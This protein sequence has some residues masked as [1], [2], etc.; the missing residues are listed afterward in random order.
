MYALECGTRVVF[1]SSNGSYFIMTTIRPELLSWQIAWNKAICH[2]INDHHAFYKEHM[3]GQAY[4]INMVEP[5]L[6]QEL[7]RLLDSISWEY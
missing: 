3:Y 4:F 7:L 6:G 2:V 5:S 1:Q